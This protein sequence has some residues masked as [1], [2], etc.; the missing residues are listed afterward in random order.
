MDKTSA[1]SIVFITGAF[2]SNNCWN[3]WILYF[4]NEGYSCIAPA[5]PY[6]D[7]SAEDLRNRP[8]NDSISLNT[9]ISVTNHFATIINGLPEKPILIGHSLGGLVVQLLL[10]RQ[11]GVA[12]IAIHS[13]PPQGVQRFR[14]SF[15]R[16]IWEAMMLFSSSR[17]TYMISFLKWKY[18]IA[19]GMDCELQ[20]QLF[21]KYA[22]PESK[23]ISET[24]SSAV[25]K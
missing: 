11:L 24:S 21:Y 23:K 17:Q 10:Q 6:K 3:E 9:I 5:W 1:R 15:L 2:V 16:V 12:G 14:L 4:E 18:T 8:A 13:F 7:A 20:K 22:I 25:Q 19:N